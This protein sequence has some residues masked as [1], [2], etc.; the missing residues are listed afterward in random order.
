MAV[1][2]KYVKGANLDENKKNNCGACMFK[3][4]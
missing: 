2:N 3:L 1:C 4:M